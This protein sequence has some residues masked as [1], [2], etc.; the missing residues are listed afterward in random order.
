MSLITSQFIPGPRL[1]DGTD[2]NNLVTQVN[3]AISSIGPRSGPTYFVNAS[4]G[5]VVVS[6]S[7]HGPRQR[8]M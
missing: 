2:L 7:T 6:P 5:S 1:I 8:L 3:N 4:L